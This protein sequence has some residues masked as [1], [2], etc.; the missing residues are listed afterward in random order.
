[1]IIDKEGCIQ[2]GDTLVFIDFRSDRMREICQTFGV[3]PLFETDVVRQ[4][5]TS[6]FS[7]SWDFLGFPFVGY[8]CHCQCQT[9]CATFEQSRVN[10]YFDE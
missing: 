5:G 2:D 8:R 4:V 1:M 10:P 7:L 6:P 9:S 3:K